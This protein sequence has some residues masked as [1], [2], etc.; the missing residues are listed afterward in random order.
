[1]SQER[2]QT[3]MAA[4]RKNSIALLIALIALALGT[5]TFR[6]IERMISTPQEGSVIVWS[7]QLFAAIVGALGLLVVIVAGV[8]A[9][10]TVPLWLFALVLF[11]LG[12]QIA[13]NS[14]P[15]VAAGRYS[16]VSVGE[17]NL[18]RADT[19]TGAVDLCGRPEDG[20]FTCVRVDVGAAAPR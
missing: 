15:E 18:W 8:R 6:A 1:M 2:V 3:W 11:A 16:F 14:R 13:I 9:E 12:G 19:L 4:A 20:R 7:V 17:A 10:R 5:D